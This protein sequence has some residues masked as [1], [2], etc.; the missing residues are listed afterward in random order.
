M[1]VAGSFGFS[2]L[3]A[4]L[5]AFIFEYFRALSEKKPEDYKRVVMFIEAYLGWVP[6]LRKALRK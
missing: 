1:I 3:A 2:L 6:G 4:V 5:L